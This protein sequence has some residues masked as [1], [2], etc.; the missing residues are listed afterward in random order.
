MYSAPSSSSVTIR[1][2][3]SSKNTRK[4]D[5]ADYRSALLSLQNATWMIS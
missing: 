4:F 2:T 1:F 5:S 3:S